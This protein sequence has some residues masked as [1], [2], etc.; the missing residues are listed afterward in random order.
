MMSDCDGQMIFGDLGGLKLPDICLTGEEKPRKN[1][2]KETCPDRGSNSGPL[3][4]RRA[5]CRLSHSGGLHNLKFRQLSCLVPPKK[6]VLVVY[7][8]QYKCFKLGRFVSDTLYY[9][10]ESIFFRKQRT[11]RYCKFLKWCFRI[12]TILEYD[13]FRENLISNPG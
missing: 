11:I 3:R 9:M 13:I 12:Q 8:I 7:Y 1:L 6:I 10:E 2:T 5:C 4:D